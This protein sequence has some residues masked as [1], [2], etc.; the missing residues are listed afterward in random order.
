MSP[1]RASLYRRSVPLD[2]AFHG[3]HGVDALA[4]FSITRD[5]HAVF[6]TATEF[7][8]AGLEFPLLFVGTGQTGATGRQAMS[9]I[10]LLGLNE[11]EN[12]QLEG[13]RWVARY[14]PAYIR[15]Y[16]FAS[17][18]VPGPAGLKVLVDDTWAG[19]SECAAEPLFTADARPAPALR[20]AI[21]FLER[22]ELEAER[23]RAFCERVVALDVL[24]EMKAEAT[25]PGGEKISVDGFH[26]IDEDRL[27]AL[28]DAT[29]LELHRTGM[30]ALMQVHLLSLANIR[31]LVNRLGVVRAR[32]AAQPA[33][34]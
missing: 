9:T 30:L 24:K 1:P 22:F 7:P 21:E 4:D 15:R 3:A 5:L 6:I 11:G 31:H 14:I 34:T 28:P 27:H 10:A 26:A 20:R 13:D 29:V 12:L 8:Q 23:T 33:A 2:P 18:T 32:G 17:A 25:L 19:F 16:P